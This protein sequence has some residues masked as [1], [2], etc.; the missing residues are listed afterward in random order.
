MNLTEANLNDN[1]VWYKMYSA[2]EAY[3]MPSL[4]PEDWN[5]FYERL[6]TDD[7][8]LNLYDK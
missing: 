2:R 8:L 7:N 6:E 3:D 5:N 1:P 4:L